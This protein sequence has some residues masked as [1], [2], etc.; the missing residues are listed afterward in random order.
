MI[1]FLFLFAL[2]FLFLQ[3]ILF[4]QFIL[5]A[6]APWISLLILYYPISK[7]LWLSALAGAILDLLSDDPIGIHALNYVVIAAFIFRFRNHFHYENP[8]HLS[9][10]TTIFS[11]FSTF[12]QLFLLFLFDKRVSFSGQWA[13]GDLFLMPIA[14]GIYALLWFSIPL[15]IYNKFR[16][17]GELYWK[18]IKRNL[19]RI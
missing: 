19:F 16:H 8:L 7:C 18:T 11:F 12:L 5:L 3:S 1:L 9:L 2:S 13:I 17:H 15:F 6:F 4:P 14:D 10:F